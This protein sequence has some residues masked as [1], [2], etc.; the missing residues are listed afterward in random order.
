MR[1]QF[2]P[3]PTPAADGSASGLPDL[4]P[5]LPGDGGLAGWRAAARE[6]SAP[7]VLTATPI[8]ESLLLSGDAGGRSRIRNE[9]R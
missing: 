8:A 9:S 4:E 3:G 6:A 5:F 7:P 1:Q 2:E